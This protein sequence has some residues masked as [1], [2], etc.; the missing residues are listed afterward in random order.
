M[1]P[2]EIVKLVKLRK[3]ENCSY[4]DIANEF[5][6][7][8]SSIQSILNRKDIRYK[9]KTGPKNKIQKVDSLKIK[10]EASRLLQEG[11]KVNSSKI[12]RNTGIIASPEVVRCFLNNNGYKY[13]RVAQTIQL[14]LSHKQA[15]VEIV[16]TLAQGSNKLAIRCIHR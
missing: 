3:K 15:R 2:D 13:K 7:P 9:R 1:Y 10:R 6:I 14:S 5:Q 11:E 12:C 4:A 16:E 8:R